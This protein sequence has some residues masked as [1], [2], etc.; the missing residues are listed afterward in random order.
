MSEQ[1]SSYFQV[2]RLRKWLPIVATVVVTAVTITYLHNVYYNTAK[3]KKIKM[4]DQTQEMEIIDR[5]EERIQ[6]DEGKRGIKEILLPRGE[7]CRAAK[8]IMNDSIEV[9]AIITGFPCMLDYDPP[10]ETDG[11]LGALAM[12]RALLACNKQVILITDE[13]NE[14][15]ILAAAAAS[16]LSEQYRGNFTLQSFPGGAQFDENDTKQ[17]YAL[18][19][20]IDLIISIERTGPCQDGS[21]RTMRGRDMTHLVAPLD[22]ILLYSQ[23]NN[24]KIISIGIGDG[25]NEVGMGKIIDKILTSSIPNAANIACI[26]PTDYLIVSS[27]SNWGGYALAVAILTLALKDHK[28][29]NLK[30]QEI[31]DL[32][33]PNDHI[34]T[35]IC[36]RL[37]DAGARDGISGENDLQIDGMSLQTS[38]QVLNELKNILADK[39]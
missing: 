20:S 28:D 12:A 27:V 2:S 25:G 19:D 18:A 24:K 23:Q 11:P 34:E 15:C 36:K 38:I 10:T 17:L 29:S 31:I 22:D 32:F 35:N 7:L 9:I 6:R 8:S 4:L 33:V 21:Y 3:K 39:L 30:T 13:C 16:T 26:V 14:E 1:L 5:L 37:V